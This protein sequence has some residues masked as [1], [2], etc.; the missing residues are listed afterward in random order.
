VL[1]E[2]GFTGERL[3]KLANTVARDELRR[4][5]ATLGD[6]YDDLVGFLVETGLRTAERYDPARVRPGYSFASYIYDI[7]A[8]RVTDFYRGKANGF[9]DRRYNPN[10]NPVELIGDKLETLA[11]A[12]G[13]APELLENEEQDIADATATLGEALSADARWTLENLGRALAEGVM[14]SQAAADAG[15]TTRRASQLLD[16]LRGELEAAGVTSG[17]L[18]S[19]GPNLAQTFENQ[20]T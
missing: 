14:I 11:A 16:E 9:A 19:R 12:Y 7:L 2:H 15:L 13:D 18:P 17:S 4:R 1:R 20:L 10:G 6:R 5:G 8:M 3:L